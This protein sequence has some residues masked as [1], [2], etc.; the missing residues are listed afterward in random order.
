MEETSYRRHTKKNVS[1]LGNIHKLYFVV[2]FFLGIV[3]SLG[4]PIFSE[5]DGPLHFEYATNIVGLS[6]DLG[7]YGISPASGIGSQQI[8]SYQ[9]GTHIQEFYV[10]TIRRV[11]LADSAEPYPSILK[12]QFWGHLIPALGAWIGYQIYPSLGVMVSFARLLNMLFCVSMSTLIIKWVR[13]GKY[14]FTLLFLSP[15]VLSQFS[16]LSYDALSYVICGAVIAFAINAIIENHFNIKQLMH[17]FGLAVVTLLM[18]KPNFIIPLLILPIIFCRNMLNQWRLRS[19]NFRKKK[20]A[21]FLSKNKLRILIFLFCFAIL[22]FIDWSF[23]YGGPFST[24][25]RLYTNFF[26]DVN[27]NQLNAITN[28][29]IKNIFVAPYVKYNLMPTWTSIVWFICLSFTLLN[30]ENITN[31]RIIGISALSLFFISF[32]VVIVGYFGA[33]NNGN[34]IIG[35]LGSWQGRYFTP[36]FL[37]LIIYVGSRP[38]L[39]FLRWSQRCFKYFLVIAALLNAILI[40]NTLFNVYYLL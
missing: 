1:F 13:K 29:S 30:T 6:N 9:R 14:F 10:Q 7:V 5:A 8:S 11:P 3:F 33:E 36:V 26:T 31:S 35:N 40:Y 22:I 12:Y 27:L 17:T 32:M 4:M 38:R 20:I 25:Q 15:V 19:D 39:S 37:L 18:A 24:L 2:A 34:L 28:S 16:S 23:N 21:Y